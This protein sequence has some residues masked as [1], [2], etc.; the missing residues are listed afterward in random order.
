MGCVVLG[1][2][3]RLLEE[4]LSGNGKFCIYCQPNLV[5]YA[6]IID[7]CKDGLVEK[8]EELFLE[9]K[10]TGICPDVVVWGSLMHGLCSMCE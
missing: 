6:S 8:A 2:S 10:G 5:C 7:L 4:M 3:L 1:V 9:M